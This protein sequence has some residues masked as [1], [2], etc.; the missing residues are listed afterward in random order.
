MVCLLLDRRK[1][2]GMVVRTME[3]LEELEVSEEEILISVLVQE[4]KECQE[5]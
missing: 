4:I 5:L 2:S 3:G 1:V